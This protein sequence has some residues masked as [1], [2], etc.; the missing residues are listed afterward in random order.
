MGPAL[1]FALL[2]LARAEPLP[3]ELDFNESDGGLEGSGDPA[4][5]EWGV[6]AAGPDPGGAR[7]WATRLD[8]DYM[9]EADDLLRLPALDLRGVDRPVL[10]LRHWY[11]IAP[12]DVGVVELLL[13]GAWTAVEPVYG[14]PE[15]E[16]WTGES[17][18]WRT[19]W[20]DLAGVGDL[21]DVRLRFRSDGADAEAGWLLGAAQLAAGDPVPPQI[22]LGATPTDTTELVGPYIVTATIL[23]DVGVETAELVWVR[24]GEGAA[25]A[26]LAE[27]SPGFWTG[28]V[29]GAPPGTS[30][31]WW[32]EA[33]DGTNRAASSAQSFR[34]Y[35]PAPT[36]LR[37]PAGRV[38]DTHATLTWTPPE[39]VFSVERYR[40]WRGDALVA[41]S[42]APIA[43][44]PLAGPVDLFTV[45]ARF[46][47]PSGLFEGDR[48]GAA[49]VTASVPAV[50]ALRPTL[51]W[52]GDEVHLSLAGENLLLVEGEVGLDLGEGVE[53]TEIDV[54]DVDHLEA[55]LRVDPGATPGPRTL[56]IETGGLRLAAPT[57]VQL[58]PGDRRPQI[59]GLDPAELQPGQR[60]TVR[61]ALSR[62]LAGPAQRVDAGEG[63][64]VG[65]VRP[66]GPASAPLALDVELTAL[67]DAVSGERELTIDDGERL[68]TGA[69]LR[70]RPPDPP[71]ARVCSASGAS[72]SGWLLVVGGLVCARARRRLRRS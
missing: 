70:I 3:L 31:V 18:G 64:V 25:R 6:P 40:V 12:G 49:Q 65:A 13:D 4:Q 36:G 19:D 23:D 67:P 7:V 29:P 9:H 38:V 72:S 20:I 21:H 42:T 32:I 63:L 46:Q 47:T 62:A 30:T 52:A 33:D 66:V 35:L 27:L 44:A 51:A 59:T 53:I 54:I 5:W 45:S 41:E 58:E 17:G 48:S 26:P 8:R 24:E 43:D 37:G 68:W 57:P 2:G 34:V 1:A 10:G 69:T 14:S 55:E 60:A 71:A 15:P 50:R 56:W 61:L 16:G 11:D 39:S 28:G 22:T